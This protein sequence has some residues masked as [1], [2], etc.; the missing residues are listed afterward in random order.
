MLKSLVFG[1]CLYENNFCQMAVIYH[2][3]Y[4]RIKRDVDLDVFDL[5]FYLRL[6]SFTS[7]T[8]TVKDFVMYPRP[9]SGPL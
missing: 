3:C 9:D 6:F 7:W 2:L 4:S 8:V 5:F 1:P